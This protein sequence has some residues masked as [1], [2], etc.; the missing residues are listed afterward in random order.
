[1]TMDVEL[2]QYDSREAWLAARTSTLGASESAALLGLAPDGRESEFS[3]WTK[4]TGLVEPEE[5]DAEWLEWGQIL[6]EPIAQRYAKRTGHTLWAPPTPWCV[7]VHPR[8]PFL[9]ATVD[10]WIIEAA[11]HDDPGD[12]EIKNVGAFNSDWRDGKDI[13]LPLYVQAQVQHQLAVTG[14]GW[15]VVAALVGGNSLKTIEVERNQEFID[16]LEAK[17]V[18]F[19]GRVERKEAP[20]ID[21]SVASNK[22]IKALHPD[23]SGETVELTEDAVTL[24]ICLETAKEAEKEAKADALE[25][26]NKL[27]AMLGAAT[28][29]TLPD[30]RIVSLKTT[31]RKGYTAV[32][33]PTK[34]RTLKIIEPKGKKT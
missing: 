31:E 34:F 4:K 12:L 8:F 29:G 16:E 24:A 25:A 26:D 3:L 6:E 9:T 23:D 13:A 5:L 2:K 30:G 32:V 15:A 10:R 27:R 18:E 28:F 1:M 22:A 20:A 21:G 7:A 11:G 33:E 17:A 19:W 14:L